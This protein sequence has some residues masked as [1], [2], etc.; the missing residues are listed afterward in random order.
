MAKNGPGGVTT[1]EYLW[2]TWAVLFPT[3]ADNTNIMGTVN[4]AAILMYSDESSCIP[5]P[6]TPGNIVINYF[7]SFSIILTL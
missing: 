5:Y 6:C 2:E 3:I 4:K 7:R 1:K